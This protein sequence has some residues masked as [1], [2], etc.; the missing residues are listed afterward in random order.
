MRSK[1]NTQRIHLFQ[2]DKSAVAE[3][4]FKSGNH[5]NLKDTTVLSMITGYT[6]SLLKEANDI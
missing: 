1:E 5:M 6:N 3:Q 2:P 4:S